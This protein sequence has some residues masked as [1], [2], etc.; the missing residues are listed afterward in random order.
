M[1]ILCSWSFLICSWA[2]PGTITSKNIKD[3][4]KRYPYDNILFSESKCG[5]CHIPKPARSK[6]CSVCNRSNRWIVVFSMNSKFRCVAKFDHHCIWINNCVGQDNHRYFFLFLFVNFLAT[7]YGAIALGLFIYGEISGILFRPLVNR[8]TGETIILSHFPMK[9]IDLVVMR[10]PILFA[11]F[12]CNVAFCGVLI[13]FLGFHM[14]LLM[15]GM[16]SNESFKWSQIKKEDR[17]KCVNIYHHGFWNNIVY[18]LF[19]SRSKNGIDTS[20]HAINDE[21][22]PS[23]TQKVDCLFSYSF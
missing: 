2:D 1:W 19:P 21:D 8:R 22:T 7:F 10:F 23:K 3:Q 14:V 11:L 17:K 12:C 4:L 20:S 9:V 5:T 15:K 16:T 18:T 13:G 6:H